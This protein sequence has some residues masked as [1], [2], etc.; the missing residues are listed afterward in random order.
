MATTEVTL[1]QAAVQEFS[2]G[3]RGPVLSPGD[4]GYDDARAIW[5]GLIDRR[6]ALIVQPTGAAD[7][8]DAVN[9]AREHG[10]TLSI[11]GGGH[12]VAGN[13]VNDG[14]LVIDLSRTRGVHVDPS[15]RR[16]RAQ[17]G[18]TWGDTDRE[19]QLFGLA[20]PGGVVST[21]GIAGLTLHGG[22]GHLRRTHGLSI[23][24][25]VS[26]DIVTADGELRRASAT[27]NEDLFWAVR[28]AG[29]NFGVVT[30]FEFQAHPVGPMVMVGA[31]FYPLEDV[32]T[33]LPAWRDY[34]ATA[35]DE[36]SSVAICWSVPAEEPFPPELHGVPVFVVAGAYSGSV[37][38]GEPVVQPLRELGEPLIDLSGPWPWLGLQSGFDELYPKGGFYYWKSRALDEMS[39]AAIDEIADFAARRPSPLTDIVIWHQGGAMSAVGESETAYGGRATAF[40]VTGEV[41]W[42][43]PALN[44]EAIAWGR[45]FWDAMGKYS[46]GGLY[47]NFAGL[48]EEKEALVKAAYG[49]NYERLAE[50]KA[51]Y[52]PGNLFRMNLNITPAS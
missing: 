8:V 2:A 30:S 48:G 25:L 17:G 10:L 7:V 18:A 6:P 26:V 40:L 39:E 49:A 11:K 19:T 34:M 20:V 29:S 5:N 13:A 45:E 28:G 50:L 14:G 47:L 42:A 38:D 36:L 15:T 9:F 22:M 27:E 32:K 31:I 41:S 51:K 12:N 46:S 21:T 4:D 35:P 37:E 52:D 3:V 23:D 44:D 1:D 33:L 43:D 16:V 24:S